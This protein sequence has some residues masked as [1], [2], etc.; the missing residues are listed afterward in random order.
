MDKIIEVKQLFIR[1]LISFFVDNSL[2]F[3]LPNTRNNK[4]AYKKQ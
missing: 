4:D 2:G 1:L 3:N